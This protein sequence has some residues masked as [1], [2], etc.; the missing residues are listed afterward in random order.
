MGKGSRERDTSES[1]E[2]SEDSEKELKYCCYVFLIIGFVVGIIILIIYLYTDVF[3]VPGRVGGSR[4]YYGGGWGCFS[5]FTTVWTKNESQ[6]DD[7]AQL[8]KVKNLE[9]GSLVGTLD[10]SAKK[11]EKNTFTWTRATDVTIQNGNWKAHTFAFC[12]GIKL[13]VTSP[14]LMIIK[15][16]G[17][18]YFSRAD[19]VQIGDEMIVEKK[20]VH[21]V[22]IKSQRI[23]K[24]VA[25]ETEDGT[26]EANGIFASGLCDYNPDVTNRILKYVMYTKKY[27][28]KHFGNQYKYKCMDRKTWKENYLIN[29]GML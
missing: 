1:S 9:E 20:L 8:I 28:S 23:K 7:F 21:V 16:N 26:I 14:H 24:K 22:E 4:G 17:E 12:N 18:L 5:E 15:K 3:Y 25:V 13:T 29:N 11:Y 6:S 2:E 19:N 10:I 27:K